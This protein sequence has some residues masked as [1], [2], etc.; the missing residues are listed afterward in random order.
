MK[1]LM[2]FYENN[3]F[4][5]Y[6]ISLTKQNLIEFFLPNCVEIQRRYYNLQC[7]NVNLHKISYE[8]KFLVFVWYQQKILV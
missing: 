3:T 7:M 4:N 5:C 2:F 6:F 8:N 1:L